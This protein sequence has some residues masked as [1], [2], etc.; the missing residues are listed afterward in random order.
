MVA[1]GEQALHVEGDLTVARDLFAKAYGLAE[2]AADAELMATAA[3]GLGGLWVHEHRTAADAA[4][5]EAQQRSALARLD[6]ASSLALRLRARLAA[7]ADYRAVRSDTVLPIVEEARRAGDPRALAEALSVAH[8]CLLGPRDADLRLLLAEELLRAGSRTGRP[9]DVVM[10]LLWRTVDLFLLGDPHAERSLAELS[11]S[12]AA[13]R[14][15]AVSFARVGMQVMLHIRGGRLDEAEA[16]AH[17]CA[18]RGRTTG[19][20]DYLGWYGAQLVAVRW[21]QGRVG[22]LVGVLA[23]IV[24][25]PM[26]SANDEAFVAGLAVA[27]ATAGDTRMARGAL[28]RLRGPGLDRLTRS[29]TWLCAMNGAAEAACLLGD[30]DTAAQVYALVLPYARL[31]VMASLAAACFGSAQHTLGVASLA[32][33]EVDRA[34]VHFRTAVE[35]NNALGHWPAAAVSRH[36]LAQAH[37][38][39]GET[40]AATSERAAATRE[41]AALGMVLPETERR[42]LVCTK[43]GRQWMVELGGRSVVVDDSV[44]M[45]YLATLVANQGT[46]I[47]AIDLTEGGVAEERSAQPVLD[48]EALQQYRQR[49]RDL[50]EEIEDAEAAHQEVRAAQLRADA[51]WLAD[52]VRAAT[53]LGGRTRRFADNPERARIAVGKAIRRAVDRI[54]AADAVL[55][56]HLRGSVQ[57]GMRCSYRG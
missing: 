4:S 43:T 38:L 25:S 34:V 29:S 49:L 2:Q 7:E 42:A 27:S 17:E 57:T 32:L 26:L 54:G 52:E 33:G 6:P 24:N 45:R 14:N 13:E 19:D 12:E 44:G 35:H 41:A 51:E 37:G 46:E 5:V 55:G 22:E 1:A 28:A 50:R 30:T 15:G 47:A 18:A 40:W 16:L 8:H 9:S 48:E 56:E 10:G 3:I 11:G 36:R 20:A 39:R 23:D 53:G 21:Y 31:P